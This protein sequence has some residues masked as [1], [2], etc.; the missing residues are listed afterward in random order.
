MKI[1][2]ELPELEIFGEPDSRRREWVILIVV[3]G[4]YN[5]RWTALLSCGKCPLR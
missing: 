1:V 2:N 4:I 5:C 3:E